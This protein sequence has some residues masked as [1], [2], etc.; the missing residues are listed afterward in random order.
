MHFAQN[1]F[2][3]FLSVSC[4][5]WGYSLG[6]GKC[7]LHWNQQSW[8]VSS[9]TEHFSCLSYLDQKDEKYYRKTKLEVVCLV[10]LTKPSVQEVGRGGWFGF[11]TSCSHWFYPNVSGSRIL[12]KQITSLTC[13]IERRF[14]RY[15]IQ[16]RDYSCHL[17]V[18]LGKVP[19]TVLSSLWNSWAICI[20]ILS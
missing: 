15:K 17:T 13:R 12:R 2:D 6:K 1:I 14:K 18:F 5:I 7:R 9:L 19:G 10:Q 3:F 4:G 16:K 20:I 11:S 8:L